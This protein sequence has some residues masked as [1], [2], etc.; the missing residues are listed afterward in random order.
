MDIV[1]CFVPL[2]FVAA[3]SAAPPADVERFVISQ[4]HPQLPVMTVYLDIVD[5]AGK[6]VS[7]LTPTN[8]TATLGSH[9]AQISALKPFQETAEGVAYAF[10]VD[11]SRSLAVEQFGEM[12]GAIRTWIEGMKPADRAAIIAFGEDYQ[13]LVDFTADKQKLSQALDSLGPRDAH[14]RLY[15]AI[16]R[17][18]ELQQRT[19]PGL[20][21]RRVLIVLSDGKDE[22]SALTPGDVLLKVRAGHLPIYSI[23]LSHLPKSERQRYLDTLYRFS[24]A[25]GGTYQEAGTSSIPQLYAMIQQ[26]VM[27]VFVSGLVCRGCPADGLKHPLEISLTQGARGLKAGPVDVVPLAAPVPPP[28]VSWW[29]QIPFWG[30][31]AVAAALLGGA[32][33]AMVRLNSGKKDREKE[34]YKKERVKIPERPKSEHVTPRT[35]PEPAKGFVMKFSVVIGKDAGSWYDVK[36]KN[37][38]VI[39]RDKDCQ[40]VLADPEVSNRHCELASVNGQIVIYDLGSTNGTVV[41][42]VPISGRH[43]LESQDTII[44]GDTELRVHF[45]EQ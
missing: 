15:Q 26:A 36:L 33:F 23:G 22:G 13:I 27:R 2:A 25:S 16:D 21:V 30:W 14:T 34:E 18:I 37:K 43:K 6:P 44:I 31:L 1:R 8:L 42:G 7:G 41:N 20:P 38:A 45:E 12:R 19:D 5:A 10:L 24:N 4:V 3:A 32:G 11:I 9:N 29:S 35:D 17:A 39:G 28:Q 40:V